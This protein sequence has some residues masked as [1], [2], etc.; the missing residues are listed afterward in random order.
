MRAVTYIGDETFRVEERAPRVPG[1]GEVRIDVAYVG[2]CGT[3]L[4]I[5]HGAMRFG[6]HNV[7]TPLLT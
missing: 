5:K 4:H 7:L 2:I 6:A 1:R 3:D